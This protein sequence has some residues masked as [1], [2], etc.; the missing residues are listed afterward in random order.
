ML[1]RRGFLLCPRPLTYDKFQEKGVLGET[2]KD[3]F[4]NT[5]FGGK[6]TIFYSKIVEN[7]FN[8]CQGFSIK[9]TRFLQ[10]GWG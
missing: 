5:L 2:F 3:K 6:S 10:V 9:T 1:V 8:K 7:W 4:L